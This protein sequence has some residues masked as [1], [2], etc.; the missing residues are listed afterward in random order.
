MFLLGALFGLVLKLA[1]DAYGEDFA[2]T[3][4]RRW[5]ELTLGGL[6]PKEREF[7]L[8]ELDSYLFEQ[9]QADRARGYK[10]A[11]VGVRT[12]GRLLRGMR[13]DIGSKL[14]CLP[15]FIALLLQTIGLPPLGCCLHEDAGSGC[16]CCDSGGDIG[17]RPCDDCVWWRAEIGSSCQRP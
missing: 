12:L 4:V 10:P 5:H 6:P 16:S 9:A 15:C 3:P 7:K 14:V 11:E 17:I 8:A 2:S 13:A 1:T